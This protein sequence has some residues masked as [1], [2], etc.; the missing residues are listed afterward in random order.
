MKLLFTSTLIALTTLLAAQTVV[1]EPATSIMDENAVAS[2]DNVFFESAE[3]LT[4]VSNEFNLNFKANPVFGDITISYDLQ[5]ES[6]VRL[7]VEK[8]GSSAIALVDGVQSTGSQKVLWDEHIGA[9]KYKIKLIVG[10]KIE[11]KTLNLSF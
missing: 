9:G 8:E 6:D 4:S 10:Q 2:V 11:T 1:F 5:I 7:E 3:N